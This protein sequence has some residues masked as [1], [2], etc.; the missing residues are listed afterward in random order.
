VEL[1]SKTTNGIE[2]HKS[3]QSSVQLQCNLGRPKSKSSSVKS[4]NAA[5]QLETKTDDSVKKRGKLDPWLLCAEVVRQLRPLGKKK[6]T[7]VKKRCIGK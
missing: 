7:Y 2:Q 4:S 1:N 3:L 6:R 5:T